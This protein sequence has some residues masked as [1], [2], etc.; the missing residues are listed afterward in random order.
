[1]SDALSK[2]LAGGVGSLLVDVERLGPPRRAASDKRFQG[3]IEP[4]CQLV[5]KRLAGE[6]AT[7]SF[8]V[9][10]GSEFFD[11]DRHDASLFGEPAPLVRGRRIPP[12]HR[13]FCAPGVH[14]GTKKAR[15]G[16]ASEY[17]ELVFCLV[18]TRGIEPL[19][20]TLQM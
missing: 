11:R 18:E 8:G 19:T 12:I 13:G 4:C 9:E 16:G 17:S 6:P 20:S 14:L 5:E 2:L 1:M 3:I 10:P 15:P 7:L